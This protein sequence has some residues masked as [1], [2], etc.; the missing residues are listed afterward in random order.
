M[1]GPRRFTFAEAVREIAEASG[2][3]IDDRPVSGEEY[4]SAPRS[5]GLVDDDVA[6]LSELFATVWTVGAP[7]RPTGR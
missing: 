3:N 7:M 6:D 1:T 2:T 5:E 4:A